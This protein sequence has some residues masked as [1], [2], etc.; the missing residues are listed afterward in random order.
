MQSTWGYVHHGQGAF[1]AIQTSPKMD[2]W[3][4]AE[5]LAGPIWMLTDLLE[6]G[7]VC[8]EKRV[9]VT[10]YWSPWILLNY[11]GGGSVWK[12]TCIDFSLLFYVLSHVW[13]LFVTWTVVHQAPLSMGFPRKEYWS[14]LPFLPPG[15][16]PDPENDSMSLALAGGLFTPGPPGKPL[17]NLLSHKIRIR[18]ILVKSANI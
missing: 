9:M 17:K 11:M 18:G 1:S 7:P 3:V 10:V 15:N 5:F 16:L 4:K 13:F 8:T 2:F 12:Q 14:G 6:T